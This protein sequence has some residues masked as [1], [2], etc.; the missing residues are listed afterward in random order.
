VARL[1]DLDNLGSYCAVDRL[2]SAQKCSGKRLND[3][4]VSGRCGWPRSSLRW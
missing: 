4:R 3:A 1:R 2:E